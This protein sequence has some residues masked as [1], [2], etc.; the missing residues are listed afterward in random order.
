MIER[1]KEQKLNE[2]NKCDEIETGEIEKDRRLY[3]KLF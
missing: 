3:E 2:C 1:V